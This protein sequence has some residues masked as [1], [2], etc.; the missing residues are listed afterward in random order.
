MGKYSHVIDTLP[1]YLGTEPKYQER[2]DAVKQ[3][4]CASEIVIN[5]ELLKDALGVALDTV[6]KKVTGVCGALIEARGPKNYASTYAFIYTQI[7]AVK[8]EL[9]A[10]LSNL[11]LIETAYT[12]LMQD[13]FE[14]EGSKSLTL[15]SGGNVRIQLE[16]YTKVEDPDAF[17]RWCIDNGMENELQLP[18]MT[19]NSL[20]KARLSEGEPEPDGVKLFSKPKVV[21]TKS[22]G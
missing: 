6:K 8:E 7:R 10:H 1:R 15:E 21:Y 2:V 5:D 14:V 9:E 12:Q 17:R 20:C 11:N 3:K 13:Q 18:W 22:K 4:I 19:A 16:P